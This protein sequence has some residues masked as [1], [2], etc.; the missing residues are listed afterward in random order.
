MTQQSNPINIRST[1]PGSLT[2]NPADPLTSLT[3]VANYAEGLASRA[4]DW[5]WA[6]K[7]WKARLS[8]S[9]QLGAMVATALAALLPVVASFFA[10]GAN[11]GLLSSALVG[12]AAALIGL[13]KAF[14]FSSGWARYVLTATS[15]RK[16]LEE[17]RMDWTM[18]LAKADPKPT[19]EQVGALI[20]RAK[21]FTSLIEGLVLQETKDWITEFQSNLAQIERDSKTQL[22]ELKSQVQKTM[23]AT[24]GSKPAQ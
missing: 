3:D 18:L 16:A 2:W 19:A 4:S 5:Y 11:T 21:D 8:R 1:Q 10:P 15:I 9:I 17:F 6:N 12:F 7:R 24:A 13:D 23:A 20:Q 14:G 22:D